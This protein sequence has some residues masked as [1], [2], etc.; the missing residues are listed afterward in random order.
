M[1]SAFKQLSLPST[2]NPAVA[3]EPIPA[4]GIVTTA[5]SAP[6]LNVNGASSRPATASSNGSAAA[7]SAGMH[8]TS[9]RPATASS[10][11][12]ATAL[13]AGMPPKP[14]PSS[15]P[16]SGNSGRS[17]SSVAA[18][19]STV[20]QAAA[21]SARR[22]RRGS[23]T[24]EAARIESKHFNAKE[25]QNLAKQFDTWTNKQNMMDRE[26]FRKSLGLLG[27][28]QDALLCHQLFRVFNRSGTGQINFEEYVNG[29]GVLMKGTLDEKLDFSFNMTD[30]DGSGEISF[31]ELLLTVDSMMRIYAGIMGGGHGTTI[32]KEK[33]RRVFAHLDRNHDGKISLEEY[34]NGMKRHPEFLNTLRGTELFRPLSGS[35]SSLR[36]AN[37]K[38]DR[39]EHALGGVLKE[40][41]RA[42]DALTTLRVARSRNGLTASASPSPDLVDPANNNGTGADDDGQTSSGDNNE[43]TLEEEEAIL[44]LTKALSKARLITENLVPHV[45]RPSAA[46]QRPSNT[47]PLNSATPPSNVTPTHTPTASPP[48]TPTSSKATLA[49]G[50]EEEKVEDPPSVP[51]KPLPEKQEAEGA[52]S[53]SPLPSP[54][55]A[56]RSADTLTK[57]SSTSAVMNGADADESEDGEDEWAEDT[58]EAGGLPPLPATSTKPRKGLTVYFGH[59]NWDLVVNVMKGIQ[60]AVSRSAM[61]QD[62]PVSQYDFSVKEKYTLVSSQDS[63]HKGSTGGDHRTR[64]V[65]YAPFVFAKLREHFHID[66]EEYMNSI[67]P[68]SM[69]SNLMLGSLSSLAEMGSEGK[70]GSFF[71]LSSDNR[72]LVKTVRKDE[73]KLLRHILP[74]Y[75]RHMTKTG[76]N[77][78]LTPDSMLTRIVGCHVVRSSK[79]SKTRT[80]AQKVYFVVMTNALET[81]L[82]VHRKYDLKG[83]WI[84]RKSSQAAR[85]E[86]G[87]TLKDVDFLDSQDRIFV[88]ARMKQQLLASLRRDATFLESHHIIDYSVLLGVHDHSFSL[89]SSSTA[90]LTKERSDSS[91]SSVQ[92]HHPRSPPTTLS[93]SNS[94]MDQD[95]PFF[96]LSHGG[97]KSLDM[98]QT[99]FMGIIDFLTQYGERKRLERFVKT[100]AHFNSSG[101]SVMPARSYAKRFLTFMEQKVIVADQDRTAYF[102]SLSS[103]SA[104]AVSTDLKRHPHSE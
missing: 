33:I 88:D 34:K 94:L 40:L 83:S 81:D 45:A 59:K 32:D 16:M 17:T 14:P 11:A 46:A 99:Y 56:A 3:R 104:H 76:Q 1:Q 82:E 92:K 79:R 98:K 87:K 71:Y 84:G 100:I 55:P 10:N 6:A 25:L 9:S 42:E 75:F 93:S 69:L 15:T 73:H 50:G 49:Q 65:D 48:V 91:L 20:R 19:A 74:S 2:T 101:L 80:G 41:Y 21:S 52:P 53:S 5:A 90:L 24:F 37:S 28:V 63:N 12:S 85:E 103:T 89:S 95:P 31:E 96:A 43:W 72:F 54:P 35:S 27:M 23:I 64:F 47:P 62:R 30:I 70:S 67:G 7:L 8:G 97:F 38:I 102:A 86:P 26:G 60:M 78:E 44:E 77:P 58:A 36:A 4:A 57:V 39:L 29:L 51:N 18:V 68:G 13:T 61:E 22:A 66:H